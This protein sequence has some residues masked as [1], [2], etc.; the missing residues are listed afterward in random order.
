MMTLN[1]CMSPIASSG[2]SKEPAGLLKNSQNRSHIH[3]AGAVTELCTLDFLAKY[4]H[5]H[6]GCHYHLMNIHPNRQ[7]V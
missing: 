3:F 1:Y 7:C 2:H 6:P 5:V 4:H